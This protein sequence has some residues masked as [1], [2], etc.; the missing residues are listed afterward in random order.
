MKQGLP[1]FIPEKG[2]A[3]HDAIQLRATRTGTGTHM[4][5]S[6][7]SGAVLQSSVPQGFPAWYLIL[8]PESMPER[9][10]EKVFWGKARAL[11]ML[12]QLDGHQPLESPA[13]FMAQKCLSARLFSWTHV[14]AMGQ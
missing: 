4:L 13:V 11:G 9:V 12:T 3:V 6:L 2:N 5:F 14:I 7:S 1:W 8:V 10:H